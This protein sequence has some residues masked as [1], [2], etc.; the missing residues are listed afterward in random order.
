MKAVP[1]RPSAHD[2]LARLHRQHKALHVIAREWRHYQTDLDRALREITETSSRALEVE[3]VSVWRYNPQQRT[4]V[5]DDLYQAT[6]HSHEGGIALSATHY[7]AYFKA[8]ESEEVIHAADAIRDP[9]TCALAGSYLKPKG[10]ASI[11]D[12][13][14]HAGGQL[15]GVLCHEHVGGTRTFHEDEIST[16][17]LLASLVGAAI[18]HLES[19]ENART[20][21]KLIQDEFAVWDIL[22]NHSNDGIV[23]LNQDG[24]VYQANKRYAGM[25]GYSMEEIRQLHVWDWECQFSK[26]EILQMLQEI[27]EAGFHFESRQRRK[28]GTIIDVELGNNGTFYKDKKLVFCIVRDIVDRKQI[29]MELQASE[30]RYRT[31]FEGVVD[32]VFTLSTGGIISSLNTSFERKTGWLRTDWIGKPFLP[33]IHPDDQPLIKTIFQRLL[34]GETV[35][36]VELR[37]L[38]RAGSYID[39]EVNP[40]T[41]NDGTQVTVF[42]VLRD[43]TERKR[44]EE[45]V[46][47]FATI[48]A[49]T[50]I[51][52]R[53]EFTRIT[54]IEIE[55]VRRYGT[56]FTLLMYDLD[57][58]KRVNDNFGHDVGDYVLQTVTRVVNENM[59]NSDVAGRWG[60]EE[61]MVLLPQTALDSGIKMAEKLRRAIEQFTF[62]KVGQVTASFGLTEFLPDDDVVSLTKRVDEALYEAKQCGR[63]RVEVR[64]Q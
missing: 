43:I 57:H 23:V 1:L 10:I 14:I 15:V 42:G 45:Q 18:E 35:D 25:L 30:F 20:I 28:D 53:R 39:F 4:I 6:P 38:T 41:N 5:C 64:S 63:N 51:L 52:N 9:R 22:F 37:I 46:L 34:Q 44:T 36:A 19:V 27:D 13:P 33:I 49:L 11:L 59:R 17:S 56:T 48:D 3:R 54:E 40:S 21:G 7:P 60:G 58:F 26:T 2:E 16:A 55:R 12:A 62:D 32:I 50:G 47:R 29:E 61:F 31:I 24:S 8:M